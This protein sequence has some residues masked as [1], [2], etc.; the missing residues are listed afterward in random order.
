MKPF[1]D[2]VMELDF[3]VVMEIWWDSKADFEANLK[4]ITGGDVIKAILD[5]EKNLFANFENPRVF[6]V[7]EEDSDLPRAI[8]KSKS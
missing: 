4:N 5:D 2:E 3:D 8:M 7:E 1:T 6:T